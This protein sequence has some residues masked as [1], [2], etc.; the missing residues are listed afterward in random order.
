V[1][2]DPHEASPVRYCEEDRE[3]F[4]SLVPPGEKA[5]VD[6]VD[7]DR[8][9]TIGDLFKD[10]V[11][12][13]Q[14]CLIVYIVAHG[15]TDTKGEEAWLVCKD[16]SDRDAFS[17][18][19]VYP[20]RELL[21][22]ADECPTA[23]K[24]LILDTSPILAGPHGELWPNKFSEKLQQEVG[25]LKKKNQD[26]WVLA[27]CGP[28]EVEHYSESDHRS[29][30]GHFV[31][32]GLQGDADG[33]S[34][35]RRGPD[36]TVDLDELF[37]YVHDNV[38]NWVKEQSN[39]LET[40]TP[41]L[42]HA[43]E[44]D[45]VRKPKSI[46]LRSIAKKIAVPEAMTAQPAGIDKPA[47]A[48]IDKPVKPDFDV[49]ARA[50]KQRDELADLEKKD[51]WSFIDY[52]PHLWREYEELLLEYEWMTRS[53]AAYERYSEAALEKLVKQLDNFEQKRPS[54]ETRPDADDIVR[55]LLDARSQFLE[56]KNALDRFAQVS[57]IKEAIRERDKALFV[58]SYGVQRH[59]RAL[60]FDTQ[61]YPQSTVDEQNLRE[62]IEKKL[63][64]LCQELNAILN[65]AAPS[66]HLKDLVEGVKKQREK[67]ERD[68]DREATA[69]VSEMPKRISAS[70]ADVLLSTP[71]LRAE[72]RWNLLKVRRSFP[73]PW[74]NVPLPEK[75]DR[76]RN[77]DKTAGE[78]RALAEH[79]K[80]ERDLACLVGWD[81]KELG[82]PVRDDALEAAIRAFYRSFSTIEDD[83]SRKDRAARLLAARKLLLANAGDLKN[84][85]YFAI[86]T[87]A[88]PDR[89]PPPAKREITLSDAIKAVVLE[90]RRPPVHRVIA[91]TADPPIQE[92]IH[93]S[94]NC[95]NEQIAAG[96][97]FHFDGDEKAERKCDEVVS[98]KL[99]NG[100]GELPVDI[101]YRKPV[102]GDRKS[103]PPWD[104]DLVASVKAGEQSWEPKR[105]GSVH[106]PRTRIDLVVR[107]AVDAGPGKPSEPCKD[108]G[109][110]ITLRPFPNRP[111]SFIFAAKNKSEFAK[112]A[113]VTLVL[114]PN[115]RL[116][117]GWR[118][119]LFNDRGELASYARPVLIGDLPLMK[120]LDPDDKEKPTPIPFPEPPKPDK[121]ASAA[122]KDS[123]VSP[124]DVTEGLVC[125]IRTADKDAWWARKI[126]FVPYMPEEYLKPEFNYDDADE[127]LSITL[128]SL[129]PNVFPP[130]TAK[131]PIPIVW[132]NVPK[133]PSMPT[134]S[135]KSQQ[136]PCVIWGNVPK[137]ES[138]VKVWVDVDECPR[139]FQYN[140][141]GTARPG[142]YELDSSLGDVRITSPADGQA[143]SVAQATPNEPVTVLL[144][145]EVNA[146]H[147][148]FD[149]AHDDEIRVRVRDEKGRDLIPEDDKNNY[150]F[151]TA[152][153]RK[154][155]LQE[156]HANGEL[157][158]NAQVRDYKDVKLPLEAKHQKVSIQ[159]EL[160]ILGVWQKASPAST[161]HVVLDDSAP[162]IDELSVPPTIPQGM[163]LPLSVKLNSL[164]PPT[165]EV[166]LEDPEKPGDFAAK[167]AKQT[168]ACSAERDGVWAASATLKELKADDYKVLVK[169]SNI[170][171]KAEPKLTAVTVTAPPEK[172]TGPA[173]GVKVTIKGS[174]RIGGFACTSGTVYLD[175]KKWQAPIQDGEYELK[176]IPSGEHTIFAVGRKAASS[177]E[178]QP[179]PIQCPAD[180]PREIT[181]DIDVPPK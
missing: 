69:I 80:L 79:L 39:G 91:V 2:Y 100:R 113:S 178:S 82:K 32:A 126:R 142:D 92:E 83:L 98:V 94:L 170:V 122:A 151:T 173:P 73:Q 29:V 11:A 18:R 103:A 145:F 24:L 168:A 86:D 164:S 64:P 13:R 106:V 174:V 63:P 96:L 23:K 146:P 49:V 154:V 157:V 132:S 155:T 123:G 140:R 127:R 134:G 22:A 169:A 107:P 141:S 26:L 25:R 15:I 163:P 179:E 55:R 71:A 99:K 112:D 135:I 128:S 172:P 62:L 16:Y 40:Q 68:W 28:R 167:P 108:D 6:L 171:G 111:T 59:A 66:A 3:A 149:E 54:P 19:G 133:G 35:P 119:A 30:F 101:E 8:S 166:G 37:Y 10:I 148:A 143:Y 33:F 90:P 46:P 27:S 109:D 131:I 65:D 88:P 31:T 110:Q 165:V 116:G 160:K 48:E 34:L 117:R 129:K 139:A 1:R 138:G 75:N 162:R 118:E 136:K 153:Q 4:R 36:G 114:L 137:K 97:I 70:I 67:L 84:L 180:G 125:V 47:K 9:N 41:L 124:P 95:K 104:G 57:G 181:K 21:Q 93:L 81:A 121:G 156:T 77:E 72:C 45:P 102:G 43:G 61:E 150:A 7:R 56:N 144:G 177:G 176:D 50:W 53:G 14:D 87:L 42:L 44:A 152:R 159:V 78:D 76:S 161:V 105:V 130:D 17:G 115:D 38:A 12:G 58:A 158:V 5:T 175:A 85:D 74:Q 60:R 89:A 20:L 147:D 120:Q 52:A 51:G